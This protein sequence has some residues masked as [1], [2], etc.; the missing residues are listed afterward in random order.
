M[1]KVVF[2]KYTPAL[3]VNQSGWELTHFNISSEKCVVY[4]QIYEFLCHA[5][6]GPIGEGD[7]REVIKGCQASGHHPA[8]GCWAALSFQSV[9]PGLLLGPWESV[10]VAVWHLV[11][12]NT[13]CFLSFSV[14]VQFGKSLE[15][16]VFHKIHIYFP[17]ICIPF[18]CRKL[19]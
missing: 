1:G 6:A 19:D 3:M 2:I 5:T 18:T 7:S 14:K 11:A 4:P 12:R 10:P 9:S 17:I 8:W 16:K 13:G 15:G